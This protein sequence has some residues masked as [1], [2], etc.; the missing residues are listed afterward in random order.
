M[1]KLYYGDC[2][3]IMR[4]FMNLGSVDLIYLDPP[5]NSNRDYNNIYKDETGRPLPDQVEG[6]NDMWRDLSPEREEVLRAMPML[7][8]ERGI[9]DKAAEFW[10]LWMQ[11]LRKLQP[12]LLSY[13]LY[14]TE[15]L[16]PMRGILKPTGSIYLHCDP[17]ASHYIKVIMD[18][19]FGHENFQNEIIWKRY[20]RPK[21]SQHKSRRYGRSSDTIL[22]Y[23]MGR[24]HTFNAYE[25]QIPLSK[26]KIENRF[27][28][29][30]DRGRF[31]SGPLIR[32]PSM[33]DRPNLVFEFQ[34]Y[35][36][37]PFGWRMGREKL[38]EI[39]GRGDFYFTSNGIPRR[40]FRPGEMPGEIIDNVWA[41]IGALGSHDQERLGY[42]TQK[43]LALLERIIAASS[44]P[45]DVVLDP[46]C[47]CATTVEAAHRLGRKWVGI[48]RTIHAITR[49]ASI[50]L[51]DRLG[52]VDGKDFEVTGVPNSITGA[53]DLWKRDPF[54]F[55]QWAIESVEG[56][57]TTKRTGD[58]GIDG[59]LY[60]DMPGEQ[61]FQSMAIEVKGGKNVGIGAVRE[62]A[63]VL[64]NDHA[65]MAGLIIL[66]PLGD[67]KQAN[68]RTFMAQAGDLNVRGVK[69]AKMQILTAEEILSGKRFVTPGPV[70]RNLVAPA[71]PL[72]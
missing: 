2:L 6:F 47:G 67:R 42:A 28:G 50:R 14:M 52:L 29:V 8:R 49:V 22:F 35:T 1:N 33:G 21:G 66:E 70:G 32:S 26:Y 11:A 71:L 38:Q 25:I 64:D 68:F 57:A 43:P 61:D 72:G 41:D 40:K 62:L 30:D 12:H 16:L 69:Y 58:G 13:L 46:F 27:S 63:G 51:R 53:Q 60:F 37:G 45:G 18:A 54:D 15:R 56:F 4:D 20:N 24:N 55:Q 39:Y 59:R 9:D 7:L 17:T 48:D 65:L 44:N 3:T 36:P 34:G 19:I 5:F 10:R 23:S 31:M